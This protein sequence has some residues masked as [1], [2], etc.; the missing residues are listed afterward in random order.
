MKK[1]TFKTL[2]CAALA[3][4]SVLGFSACNLEAQTAY[5]VAVKN[6]FVGTEQEWLASLKGS[7]G[8]SAKSPTINEIY[9]A[10]LAQDGNQGKSFD[11][12]LKEYLTV[13]YNENNN[14]KQIAENLTS[15]VSVYCGMYTYSSSNRAYGWGMS[16][17]SG[18]IYATNEESLKNGNAYIITNYHVLYSAD[19]Q[20]PQYSGGYN[21][22]KIVSNDNIFIYLYGCSGIASQTDRF[23]N[24]TGFTDA[25]GT[26]IKASYAGG[27]ML[28]DVAVLKVEGDENLKK[29]AEAG[30]ATAVRTAKNG[31]TVGEKV[32]AI[33]NPSGSGISVSQGVVSVESEY[34]TMTAAD[35]ET[36]TT[37]HVLRTDTA[38]NPGNSGGGLFNAQGELVG[39]VNAKTTTSSSGTSVEN[40][41]Y[42]LPIADVEAVANNI[43]DNGGKGYK[44]YFGIVTSSEAQTSVWD[45]TKS[46]LVLT[47][48][49]RVSS[50]SA[51]GSTDAG[52]G[53]EQ[54]KVD[55]EILAVKILRSGT[56]VTAITVNTRADFSN[57][58]LHV[59]AGDTMQVEVKRGGENVTLTF[60][61]SKN[62]M[63]TIG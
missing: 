43:I 10:W 2:I 55:D 16:A 11:D 59:R 22:P 21:G 32:Y 57:A 39:I 24:V 50:V 45:E 19:A 49:V 25:Y 47:E 63:K 53:A 8:E 54:F 51:K 23:G 4:V 20:N 28:Y 15:A 34:I 1:R 29:A 46:K 18:V 62:E 52:I 26:A 38:I 27:S 3:G 14:T 40:M 37:F 41:G 56:E 48:T 9:E 5:D 36:T 6:G 31:V 60:E 13:D 58:L 42:A 7:D 17:G 33:G 44:P 61:I 12:F 30:T 35:D